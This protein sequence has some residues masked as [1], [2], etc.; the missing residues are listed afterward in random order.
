MVQKRTIGV[1]PLARP[2]F[3]VPF[4]EENT[5]KAFEVLEK[6]GH[7][8][9]GSKEL[10]FDT[11]AAEKALDA[12]AGE[13]L[14]LLLILQVTFTDA[15]MTVAIANR[16]ETPLAIWSFPEP[17]IGGRLR[18]N[19]LCG[20]NLAGHALG[21]NDHPFAYLYATPGPDS[22]DAVAELLDGGRVAGRRDAIPASDGSVPGG[23][24]SIDPAAQAKADAVVASLKGSKIG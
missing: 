17:R 16:F 6:S 7:Q 12:L 14:D 22:L 23:P 10:L 9:I 8:I 3:D 15:S 13:S 11:D 1:L 18:L 19:S 20:L 24:A 2:T 21:L 4:A 5:A